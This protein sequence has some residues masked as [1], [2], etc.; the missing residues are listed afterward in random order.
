MSGMVTV[1]PA[2][3]PETFGAL[4]DAE[5]VVEPS[6]TPVT[7]TLTLVAPAAMVTFDG[8]VAIATLLEVRFTITPPAGAGTDRINC[9]VFDAVRTTLMELDAKV[10]LAPTATDCVAEV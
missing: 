3:A 1:T 4:E 10:K 5:I 6:V 2:L 9:R 8:T 7:G